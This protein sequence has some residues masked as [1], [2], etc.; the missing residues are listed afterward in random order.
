ME[1]KLIKYST[2]FTI[3]QFLTQFT[4]SKAFSEWMREKKCATHPTLP[5]TNKLYQLNTQWKS[6]YIIKCWPLSSEIV[7][8]ALPPQAKINAIIVAR[9][10]NTNGASNMHLRLHKFKRIEK[11]KQKKKMKEKKLN[12]NTEILFYAFLCEL[13]FIY[14]RQNFIPFL[15]DPLSLYGPATERYYCYIFQSVFRF[16]YFRVCVC[17][18]DTISYFQM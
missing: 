15:S 14:F 3:I 17:I 16:F 12:R 1:W 9:T 8:P 2:L 11:Q 18:L 10:S 5:Q 4:Q 7:F 6:I 13:M